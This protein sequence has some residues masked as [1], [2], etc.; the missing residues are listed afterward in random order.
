MNAVQFAKRHNK[1]QIME[2]L[3]QNGA[4]LA[5]ENKKKPAQTK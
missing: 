1:N 4:F 5:S 2:L 3:Q